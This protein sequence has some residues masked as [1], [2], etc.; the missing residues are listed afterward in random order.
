MNLEN[1]NL[2]ELNAQEVQEVE[3]GLSWIKAAWTIISGLA[4]DIGSNHEESIAAFKRG[5]SAF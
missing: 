4:Y 1:L 2:V 3:G 5:N